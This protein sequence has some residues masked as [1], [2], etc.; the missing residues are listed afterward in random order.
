MHS[1]TRGAIV[2][3]VVATLV[4][5]V[6]VTLG[7]LALTRDD[8]PASGPAGP[9]PT[10]STF[11]P[12]RNPQILWI[13]D[14]F[15]AGTGAAGGNEQQG[16]AYLTAQEL[17][18]GLDLD[19]EGATGFVNDGGTLSKRYA[20]YADRIDRNKRAFPDE[21]VIV[22]DGGRNDSIY[23]QAQVVAALEDFYRRLEAAWP[24]AEVV[25]ILPYSMTATEKSWVHDVV[26]EAAR[27]AGSLVIDPIGEGWIGVDQPPGLVWTDDSHPSPK[28]HRYLGEKLAERIVE[29]RVGESIG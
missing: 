25:T 3:A 18:W 10:R 16:L 13:G 23:P 4:A 17:G 2:K 28:G 12:P 8:A 26:E 1:E 20:T 11:I 21:D 6:A 7:T 22:V 9:T 5:G 19:A 15:P 14:S 24:D 29:L 27:D